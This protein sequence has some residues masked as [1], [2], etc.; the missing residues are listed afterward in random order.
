MSHEHATLVRLAA[1]MLQRAEWCTGIKKDHFWHN[2]SSPVQKYHVLALNTAMVA[3]GIT[4]E[5]RKSLLNPMILGHCYEG[6]DLF[7][8]QLVNYYYDTP[9]PAPLITAH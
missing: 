2:M 3:R 1:A 8:N 9:T 4:Y 7:M 5:I 6:P